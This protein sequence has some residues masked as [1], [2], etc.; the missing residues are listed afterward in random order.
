MP[1][2]LDASVAV[3]WHLEDETSEY[4]ERVL[5]RLST[6]EALVPSIWP[7]ELANVLLIAERRGRIAPDKVAKAFELSLLLPITVYEVS[8]E[9]AFGRAAELA[10]AHRLSVYDAT[11]LELA[12]R[13]DYALA[14]LDGGLR[15]A[16]IREGVELVD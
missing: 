9:L 14:T 12:T 1:F 8:A 7:Q 13:E 3:V 2:V 16:A 15:A 11:Y 10:R 4:S 6:D 5:E